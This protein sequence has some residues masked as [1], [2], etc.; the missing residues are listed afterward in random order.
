MQASTYSY[1]LMR[2]LALWLIGSICLTVAVTGAVTVAYASQPQAHVGFYI[3]KYGRAD[4]SHVLNQRTQ[5]IFAQVQAVADKRMHRLPQLAIVN[6]SKNWARALL[7]GYIVLSAQAIKFSYD[8]VPKALG[9]TRM[10]FILGHELAHLA[11]DDFFANPHQGVQAKEFAADAHGFIYAA[12]AGYPVNLLLTGIAQQQDFFTVWETYYRQQG[13]LVDTSDHPPAADRATALQQRLDNILEQLAFFKFGVRLSHFD[14][15]EDANYFFKE[16]QKTFPAREVFNNLGYCA[17]RQAQ[18]ALGQRAYHYCMPTLLDIVSQAETLLSAP[19]VRTI[20]SPIEAADGDFIPTTANLYLKQATTFF[21]KAS[22][23]DPYYLPALVNLAI[24]H[25][26]SGEIYQARAAIEKA[27]RLDSDNVDVLGLRDVIIYEEGQEADTWPQAI[28]SLQKL[29]QQAN[30]SACVRYNTARLLAERGRS[31]AQVLWEELVAQAATLPLQIRVP[32]CQARTCPE[33]VTGQA[34]HTWEVPVSLGHYIKRDKDVQQLLQTW[35]KQTFD[36]QTEI[37]GTL[38]Q[39]A[40]KQMELLELIGYAEMLV[41]QQPSISHA[42]L[43]SYCG[44]PLRTRQ[45]AKG[46]VLSCH[47]WAAW[48]LDEQVR[49]VWLVSWQ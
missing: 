4:P 42:E 15:C 49:E 36:W 39:S 27:R 41:L 21:Q 1:R 33:F 30:A 19:G 10:A 37:Y 29:T 11:N 3:K 25:L 17:L 31:G 13:H 46:T 44:S 22:E 24:T 38:Y 12:M 20:R 47:D 5:Q 40:D 45:I 2:R 34:Q 35:E 48:V 32:L 43:P 6:S 9:D 14:R 28:H 16:F 23:A 8:N 26:Y 7:D 18:K